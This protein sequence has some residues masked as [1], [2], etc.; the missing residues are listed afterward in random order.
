MPITSL[1]AQP[2]GLCSRLQFGRNRAD[3][4]WFKPKLEENRANF[5]N[6]QSRFIEFEVNDI[7]ICVH[8]VTEAG[9]LYELPIQ[10]QDVPHFTQAARIDLN[11]EHV[12]ANF[13]DPAPA[14]QFISQW[15]IGCEI[16][17]CEVG[18]APGAKLRK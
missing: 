12:A 1:D 4:K 8:L 13:S 3:D 5:A 14:M 11:F 10:F 7:V 18:I 15:K 17:C 6:A 9:D 16:W 2:L